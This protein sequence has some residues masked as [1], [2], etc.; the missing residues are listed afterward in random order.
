MKTP[1]EHRRLTDAL[2]PAVMAAARL[3]LSLFNSGC[4]IETKPDRSPVTEADRASETILLES[5]AVA[6]PGLA[7]VSE[8]AF[9]DGKRPVLTDPF[10]LVD[11]LDG[12]KQFIAGRKEWTIN[13][14]VIAAGR[15]VYGLIYAP[16]LCE[17]QVTDGPG[18]ALRAVFDPPDHP[19]KIHKLCLSDLSPTAIAVRSAD[20]VTRSGVIALLSQSRDATRAE[21]Y[22]AGLSIAERRRLGSS[23]KFCLIA[24]G[25][26]DLYPQFGPTSEWDTAAGEAILLAAGGAVV[27]LQGAALIYGGVERDFRNPPFIATCIPEPMLRA[28]GVGKPAA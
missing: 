25:V 3:Q 27:D 15:P 21:G 10:V 4:A 13:I 20:E 26:G 14:A 5:I 22:M 1:V 2:L 11:P 19:A 16:A 9:A 7:V 17:L 28:C 18:A 8:E 24:A 12:T 23:Y 6:L